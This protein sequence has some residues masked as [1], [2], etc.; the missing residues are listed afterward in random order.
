VMENRAFS[1]PRSMIKFPTKKQWRPPSRLEWI[2]EGPGDLRKVVFARSSRKIRST[3]LSCRHSEREMGGLEWSEVRPE[4]ERILGDLGDEDI[5]VFEPTAKYRNI[6]KWSGVESPTPARALLAEMIRRSRVPGI[7]CT[8]LE[9]RNWGGF[10]SGQSTRS[11]TTTR[12]IS[13][14]KLTRMVPTRTS[15]GRCSMLLTEPVFIATSSSAARG[16]RIRSGSIKRIAGMWVPISNRRLPHRL[17]HQG[18]PGPRSTCRCRQ[19]ERRQHVC[20]R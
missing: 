7:G 10:L 2:I 1:G 3:P 14:S 15:Y 17:R 13:N 6:A 4:V 20:P 9:V 18:W 19:R 8:Y 12:S 16:H 5:R 11:G